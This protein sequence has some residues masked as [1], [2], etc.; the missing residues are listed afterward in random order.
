MPTRPEHLLA[1]IGIH[2]DELRLCNDESPFLQLRDKGGQIAGRPR[3]HVHENIKQ[4]LALLLCK[5]AL[6][7]LYLFRT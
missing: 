3:L 1:S 2:P 6:D 4:N 5:L 7:I